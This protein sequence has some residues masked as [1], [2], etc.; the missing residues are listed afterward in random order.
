MNPLVTTFVNFLCRLMLRRPPPEPPTINIDL[1]DLNTWRF[2]R[3]REAEERSLIDAHQREQAERERPRGR[4]VLRYK[5]VTAAS[6]RVE[7]G[8]IWYPCEPVVHQSFTNR[9]DATKMAKTVASN[10]PDRTAYVVR[11]SDD[12]II[13]AARPKA[14][15]TKVARVR[16][17][18]EQVR[19]E[20]EI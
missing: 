16:R 8:Y 11:F 7:S 18:A 2:T 15:R 17:D 13:W 4:R 9:R 19:D 20:E 14:A 6:V 5:V 12:Q 1:N 3:E 10:M